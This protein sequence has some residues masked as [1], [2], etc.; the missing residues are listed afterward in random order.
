MYLGTVTRL[1]VL[2]EEGVGC[3]E[4]EG[5]DLGTVQA[6]RELLVGL[7]R[8]VPVVWTVECETCSRH[9]VNTC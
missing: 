8:N 3:D 9:T 7:L 5:G 4:T 2:M 1:S 6:L